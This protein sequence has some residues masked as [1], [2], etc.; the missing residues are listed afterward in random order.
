MPYTDYNI[1]KFKVFI[2]YREDNGSLFAELTRMVLSK[3]NIESF[4][5]H[6]ERNKH[7]E[8]FDEMRQRLLAT[9]VDFFIF[10]NTDGALSRIE[11]IKEFNMAFPSGKPEGTKFII[12][13]HRNSSPRPTSEQIK[14]KT[15]LTIPKSQN[16]PSFKNEDELVNL[17]CDIAE[18]YNITS[19]KLSKENVKKELRLIKY[20]KYCIS[21]KD[22]EN[23]LDN[24][25]LSDL[26]IPNHC[27]LMEKNTWNLED[28]K[29]AAFDN[30]EW[31]VP[32]FLNSDKRLIVIGA[33][34]GVGK[35]YFSYKLAS[36]LAT[37]T[38]KNFSSEIIPVLIRMRFKMD[39]IDDKSNSLNDILAL[40]PSNRKV[41]FIYDGL[42]EF[43][44]ASKI[45]NVYRY[46]I[47]KLNRYTNSKAIVTTR[48]N[49][50]FPDILNIQS[51]VRL[52]PFDNN[53]VNLFLQKYGVS[54]KLS[55][56]LKSG[57]GPSEIGKPL[58]CNLIAIL[59]KR[60]GTLTFSQSLLLNRVLLFFEIVHNVI[61]GKHEVE[62]VSYD[63]KRHHLNEK[64]T[65]R[66]IAQL[67]DI[68]EDKLTI[69]RIEE[70]IY[71]S[72]SIIRR[73]ISKV[74]NRLIATYFFTTSDD[75]NEE[76]IDFIHRSFIEYLLAE[77]YI[78]SFLNNEPFV[79]N[80]KQPKEE[81]VN[82][83]IGL[84]ELIKSKKNKFKQYRKRLAHTFDFNLSEELKNGLFEI[85]KKSFNDE[86]TYLNDREDY[87]GV[88]EPYENLAIHRWMSIV[89]LNKLG[90]KFKL[91][92]NKFYKLLLTTHGSTPAYVITLNHLDLS[93]SEF[94][95]D[96]P[97]LILAKANLKGSKFHGEF[98]G[99]NFSGA[100]LSGSYVDTGTNFIHCNFAG[101]N[102]TSLRVSHE[103]VY[104]AS[105]RGCDF[106]KARLKD[107]EMMVTDFRGSDFYEAD[108]SGA[109]LGRSIF[110]LTGLEK[111]IIDKTTNTRG[112]E[113][114]GKEDK[115]GRNSQWF[116][117]K[118]NKKALES[119]LSDVDP[120]FRSKIL[121][122]NQDLK[123]ILMPNAIGGVK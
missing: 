23:K 119:F 60:I 86:H 62:A 29:I 72:P 36:D 92:K 111:V 33:P 89:V 95:S 45:Q 82:F 77:F 41:M 85:A 2:C 15:G 8:A 98:Y 114:T 34:Y 118:M 107:A 57:L 55:Q 3:G 93:K 11:V 105:F 10:I 90:N 101:A 67:K 37:K 91:D 66:K 84:L 59:Y 22:T 27:V 102:L 35:T 26:Y 117:L 71:R 116:S 68:Y 25:I 87:P 63:Y 38:L 76:R 83:F 13:H 94:D 12:M 74:F 121:K 88:E 97:T 28:D 103:T 96:M 47:S 65:L 120:K 16:I 17:V 44:D 51:Y 53:Q 24:T 115:P 104:A 20:L 4:V 5:A 49:S 19:T 73:N 6:I 123:R 18:T 75:N 42:D 48:L 81:T 113:L 43:E 1:Q 78:A 100:D 14:V 80:L 122:D 32:E 56:I 64:R 9:A 70:S 69:G 54:L 109:N 61:L 58:F 50:N 7:A 79:I 110:S 112:I 52:L 30:Q 106:T 31:N 39:T 46:I 99:T 40:I 108:L 21:L